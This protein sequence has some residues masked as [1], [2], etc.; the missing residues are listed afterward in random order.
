MGRWGGLWRPHTPHGV[1][2]QSP[3]VSGRAAGDLQGFLHTEPGI[4]QA[5]LHLEQ[6]DFG[7][8]RAC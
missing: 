3:K 8:L 4:A 6:E 5:A 1:P 7:R 2:A